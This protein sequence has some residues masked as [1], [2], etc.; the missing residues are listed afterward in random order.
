M[1]LKVVVN[2]GRV[3]GEDEYV[4][5]EKKSQRKVEIFKEVKRLLRFRLWQC[6]E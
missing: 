3:L 6:F 4:D 1:V 2:V 5:T